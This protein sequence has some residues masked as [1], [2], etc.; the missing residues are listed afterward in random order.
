[1]AGA[2]PQLL[3]ANLAE[4][5]AQQSIL[6]LLV[7]SYPFG[8]VHILLGPIKQIH[9][10]EK[11]ITNTVFMARRADVAGNLIAAFVTGADG[12]FDAVIKIFVSV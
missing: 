6:D 12:N 8:D 5:G 4:S 11:C 9:E 1:M 2:A 7:L 10:Y 3:A